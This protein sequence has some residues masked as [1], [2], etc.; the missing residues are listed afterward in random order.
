MLSI[1]SVAGFGSLKQGDAIRAGRCSLTKKPTSD[2]LGLGRRRR[3]GDKRDLL[4]LDGSHI[5]AD[6]RPLQGNLLRVALGVVPALAILIARVSRPATA[7]LGFL[8]STDTYRDISIHLEAETEPGLLIFRFD[9]IFDNAGYF[10]DQGRRLIMDAETPVHE[11]LIPAQQ[12]NELDSTGADQVARLVDDLNAQGIALSFA[13]VKDTLREAMNERLAL[14]ASTS[15][16]RTVSGRSP[17]ARSGRRPYK[18]F[19]L[20]EGTAVG[21]MGFSLLGPACNCIVLPRRAQI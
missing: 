11:G 10:S 4:G 8:P 14:I 5:R 1:H 15:R 13:E 21:G 3:Q 18:Y 6:M 17:S 19:A 20:G 2:K 9:V 16:S 7:A 12:I